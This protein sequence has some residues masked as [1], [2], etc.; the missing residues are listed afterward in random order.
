M[1]D[2]FISRILEVQTILDEFKGYFQERKRA[3]ERY[4]DAKK[5]EPVRD[6]GSN[7]YLLPDGMDP[8]YL[9][10]QLMQDNFKTVGVAEFTGGEEGGEEKDM[11]S[12]K[13]G[14][15]I[16]RKDGRWMGRYYDNGIRR[17]VYAS[18]KLDCIVALNK[19]I[20]IRN[21]EEKSRTLTKTTSLNKWIE[22][23]F[24]TFKLSRLKKSSID[25]YNTNL[26]F[27][28]KKDPIGSK[29]LSAIRGIDLV[30]FFNS[31]E[32]PSAKARTFRHLKSVFATAQKN[33]LIADSP[34][35]AIDN[36]SEPKAR[37]T[38]PKEDHIDEFF[39]YIQGK[40]AS[41]YRFAKFLSLTGLRKG[42]ALALTWHDIVDSKIIVNKAYDLHA[43]KVQSPKTKAAFRE[44]PLFEDARVILEALPKKTTLVFSDIFPNA[45]SKRFSI[46]A[47]QFGINLSLHSLRHYFASQC[48]AAGIDKKL[49][50]IWLGHENYSTTIDTYTHIDTQFECEQVQRMAKYRAD[51]KKN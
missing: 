48:Y 32:A 6:P 46:Y 12:L 25:D 14:G 45:V 39:L 44:I 13:E 5:I 19:A 31:I 4:L 23:W 1:N 38:L 43:S 50:Q 20:V 24:S 27:R 42:E 21:R 51:K 33:K 16:K 30:Q 15:I 2:Y 26:I 10:D 28:I 17:H 3:Y 34:F 7:S 40:N 37:K 35:D 36:I 29:Q 11:P 22:I 47:R 49:V 8:D 9:I 41:I 18:N